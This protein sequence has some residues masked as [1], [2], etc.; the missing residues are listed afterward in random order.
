MS[1]LEA[2]ERSLAALLSSY[3]PVA[4]A[5]SGGVDSSLLCAE[6]VREL[7]E[8]AVAFTIVSPFLPRSE[9]DAARALG[10]DL[11]IRHVLIEEHDID[12]EVARNPPNRCYLCKK[13]AFTRIIEAARSLGL[14]TVVEG[15]NIDD[16]N[17]Y[18][19]GARAIAELGIKSP[20]KE[21]GFAKA[22]IREVS[23]RLGLPT[24]GKPAFACLASRL[25]YGERIDGGKLERIEHSEDYL[26]SLGF[27]QFRVR[28]HGDL[29]RIEVEPMERSRLFDA[30]LLDEISARLKSFGFI[31]VCMELE[32]YS[33]GSM[34]KAI[35]S[36]R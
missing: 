35:G 9:L 31:Y 34:N 30:M 21:A 19:P 32:G 12:E 10:K 15:S 23:K 25:P 22:E 6:A 7:G 17:D 28:S 18:R 5:F 14:A 27:H 16:D 33:M 4:V 8:K 2:K 13:I 20:L 36:S 26:R 1:E 11:G 24:W 3:G 29:A